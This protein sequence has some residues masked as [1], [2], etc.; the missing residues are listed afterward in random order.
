MKEIV[1][2]LLSIERLA[3]DFYGEIADKFKDDEEFSHFFR[4]LSNE[5][6]WHAKIMES[7]SAYLVQHIAPP[8]SIS[9]D[10]ETIEKIEAPFT[11]NRELLSAS[12]FSRDS[13]MDCL[14]TT[15]YSEWND[16]FI[17]AVKNLREQREFMPIVS[18]IHGH[19]REI[20]EFMESLPEGRKHLYILKSL[21][22]VWKERILIIDDE[23]H[24]VEFLTKLLEHE[25]RVETAQNGM[26]GLHKIKKNYFDLIITD[27]YMPVMDGIEFYSQASSDDPEIGKRIMFFPSDPTGDHED[28]FQ[29]NNLSYLIK[30][31]PIREIMKLVSKIIHKK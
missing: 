30:P 9:L 6:A 22:R 3:G 23:P 25:G 11:R 24:I 13:V 18:K 16:I 14:A 8:F 12:N 31:A 4:H 2:W 20:S 7:A 15:E 26:E 28:F 19:L 29:R 27:L 21:P 17:Y 10:G 1:D 5:E